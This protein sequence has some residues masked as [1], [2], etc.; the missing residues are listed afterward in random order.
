MAERSSA[1]LRSPSP[2]IGA[3]DLLS[4]YSAPRLEDFV[5]RVFAVLPR[6]VACDYVSAMYIGTEF[7]LVRERDSRG[8]TWSGTFMRRYTE[9]LQTDLLNPRDSGLDARRQIIAT[10]FL[11]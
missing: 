4:L 9:I 3:A 1:R 5:D 11:L 6:V 8:R 10:R 7:G 2:M